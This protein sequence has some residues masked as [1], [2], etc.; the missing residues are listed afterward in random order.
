M[1]YCSAADL[2]DFGLPRG[3]VPNAARL[4]AEVSATADTITLGS[5]GY[6]AGYQ[7]TFRPAAGGTLPAPLVQGVTYYAL[8]VDD[9]SFQ[10]AASEGGPAIDLTTAGKSVL[11]GHKLPLPQAIAW[12]SRVVDDYVPAHAVPFLDPVP[13]TVR[14]ITAE[15]AA[16]KLALRGGSGG[17]SPSLGKTLE[18]AQ[19]RLDRW[20]AGV[21]VRDS[22]TAERT[23][24]A[25]SVSLPTCDPT[26]WRRV[27][28][29]G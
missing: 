19:K 9:D 6:D 12:A 13:A 17:D 23:N 15:L 20:A 22:S 11:V 26:G 25:V 24:T 28:G 2:Y 27:G 4:A 5:H 16:A 29:I 8:P 1:D 10:V 14:H 3:S 7:V 21:P 18:F